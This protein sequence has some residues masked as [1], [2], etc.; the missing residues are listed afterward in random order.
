VHSS[1][2]S[3]DPEQQPAANAASAPARSKRAHRRP[4]RIEAREMDVRIEP[5]AYDAVVVSSG[6]VEVL[7]AR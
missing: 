2:V 1:A 7:I 6:L 4:L 5:A 3:S